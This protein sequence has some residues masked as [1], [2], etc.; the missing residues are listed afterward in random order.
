MQ[1]CGRKDCSQC[2]T[3]VFDED[4]FLE[5]EEKNNKEKMANRLCNLCVNLARSYENR[6]NGRFD[7]A[8]KVVTFEA[9]GEK[10]PRRIDFNV[11]Q[12]Q[13]I[14]SPNWCP[15]KSGGLVGQMS[16]PFKP[17]L[18]NKED[19]VTK[20]KAEETS[21]TVTP[22]PSTPSDKPFKEMTYSEKREKLKE[23][24][25][26][27]EWDDIKEGN[28]YVI[29][30]ILSQSRKVVK[31]IT[32]TDT[33]CMCHEISQYTGEEYTYSCN[34]YPSDLDAVFITELRNF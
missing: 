15:L 23:L 25:K 5:K 12:T 32:K 8:C 31:V 30:K 19:N 20:P 22:S 27:M 18:A 24:P 29:P 16:L 1:P 14:V 2:E 21:S 7:V 34:V 10:R 13:D 3:C 26:H 4:L 33:C 6:E 17:N 11:S 9:L 28:F